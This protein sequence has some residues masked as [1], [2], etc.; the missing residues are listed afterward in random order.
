MKAPKTGKNLPEN[1]YLAGRREWM[2]RY[3][4]LVKSANNWRLLALL[5]T[6]TAAIAVAGVVW[7]SGQYKVVPYAI[8]VDG[9]GEV[10]NVVRASVASQP[11]NNQIRAALRNWIIG[12]R[13][14]YVDAR[15]QQS[16]LDASYA[17]TLPESAA[18]NTLSTFHRESNPYQ[19]A[20]RET[21]E[22]AV[23]TVMPISDETW[24][25]EWTETVKQRSGKVIETSQ[26]QATIT[27]V[28]V[29]PTTERQIMAN[30]L[31][32]YARQF[33]WAPRL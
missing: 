10:R 12:A 4:D 20:S 19:R 2:E 30:P 31:G 9:H 13:T 26:M 17:M 32:I 33:A 25:V 29:P 21:V 7:H 24:R 14:I 16:I 11:T 5:S 15:A 6:A 23:N 28:T 18:F 27:V 3:G 8:E 1:P 22:V